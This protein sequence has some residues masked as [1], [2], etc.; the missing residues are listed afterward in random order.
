MAGWKYRRKG[1]RK[2]AGN[3]A[4]NEKIGEREGGHKKRWLNL[5]R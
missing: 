4:R 2:E 5:E 3:Q 1:G